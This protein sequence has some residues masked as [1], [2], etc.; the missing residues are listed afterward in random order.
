MS[1]YPYTIKHRPGNS[2]Q[3][4][5]ALSRI[6]STHCLHLTSTEIRNSQSNSDL[7]FIKKPIVQ[8]GITFIR[9]NS[10]NKAYVPPELRPKL[11][12]MFHESYSRPGKN[13]TIQIIT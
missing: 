12:N 5:D 7:T 3:H 8:N 2:I 6:T 10:V 11:L 1:T 4:V 9:Q 13:K